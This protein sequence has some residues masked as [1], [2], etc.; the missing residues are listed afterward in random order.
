ME[1]NGNINCITPVKEEGFKTLMLVGTSTGNIYICK[2]SENSVDILNK[3]YGPI[4]F[5]SLIQFKLHLNMFIAVTNENNLSFF[6]TSYNN[7]PTK[8]A[9][10]QKIL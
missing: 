1:L 9:A 2:N 7:N 3:L 5:P 8:L 10:A 6:E 4:N